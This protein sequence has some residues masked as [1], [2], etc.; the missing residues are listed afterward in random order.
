M[1]THP[2][3]DPGPGSWPSSSRSCSPCWSPPRCHGR[4]ASTRGPGRSGCGRS[5]PD[6]EVVHG[7][8]PPDAPTARATA[9]STWPARRRAGARRA[10]RPGD[11]AGAARRSGGGRRRPRRHP[12]DLRACGRGVRVGDQV[13]R[14]EPVGTLEL[15]GLAL[16]PPGLPALGL[17]PGRHLPRPARP[18][19]RRSDAAAAALARLRLPPPADPGA[20]Q[21]YAVLLATLFGDRGDPPS[22]TAE[23]PDRR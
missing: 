19:R 5:S 9:A 2:P 3:L 13:A 22:P 11:V 6:P 12:H 17:D 23:R 7:F 14:G 10:G 1:P 16:L 15:A 18:G 8:D 21:P 4:A 20:A